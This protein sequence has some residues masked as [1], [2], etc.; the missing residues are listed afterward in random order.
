MT[1]TLDFRTDLKT[2]GD[3]GVFT[4]MASTFGNKDQVGDIIEPGAFQK[5]LAKRPAHRIKLLAFHNA[6]EPVGVFRDVKETGNGLFVRGKLTLEVERARE[7]RALMRDGAL[8]ALSIGFRVPK[9][10]ASFDDK[11]RVRVLK[12]IDLLEV[13][14]VTF[15]AN[16]Q[17]LI[18]TVKRDSFTTER[19]AESA[20]RRIGFSRREAQTVIAKGFR[21]LL[22]AQ[23]NDRLRDSDGVEELLAAMN[24]CRSILT[25]KGDSENGNSRTNGGLRRL[26]RSL[27]RLQGRV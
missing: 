20:L 11:R 21:A 26:G 10:G 25:A 8:D 14:V 9:S 19:E 23:P 4:G 13:S 15:P 7:I 2:E 18:S 24:S 27:E 5:S 12:E 1:E 17:A 22:A 3:D 16:E 6:D